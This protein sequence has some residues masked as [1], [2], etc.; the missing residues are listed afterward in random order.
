MFGP[1]D[2][3]LTAILRLLRQ[4]PIYPMFGRGLTR[5]QPAYVEDVAEAVGRIMKR[6]E[7]PSMIFEF[8]GPRVYS[9]EEFLR[10]V[11]HQAGLAPLL[12]PIPFA[13]WHALTW[14]FEIL[15][16]PLLT[17][18]QVEL[19]QIDTV[20]SPEMPGFGE[21]GITPHSVE[22]ILQRMLS[23]CG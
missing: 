23:N 9:Y 11:A 18:N 4:L 8:G 5:L 10:A 21:L 12:I 17:R 19:M 3:F 15:P 20:S 16:G 13:V 1:D 6:A 22:A 14:A 2:A 7:T